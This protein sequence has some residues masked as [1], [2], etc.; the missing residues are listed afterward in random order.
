MLGLALPFQHT[1]TKQKQLE[2]VLP[3]L[4]FQCTSGAQTSQQARLLF[5]PAP[6][7]APP[8]PCA[9]LTTREESFN[10]LPVCRGNF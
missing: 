5:Y 4:A 7:P 1:V 3:R 8:H 2:G 10:R 9:I 6:S